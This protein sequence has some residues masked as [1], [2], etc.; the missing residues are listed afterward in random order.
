MDSLE[1]FHRFV[2]Q[3]TDD[4]LDESM[5]LRS[6]RNFF[7]ADKR[8]IDIKNSVKQDVFSLGIFLGEEKNHF[9]PSP[10]CIDIIS[11]MPGAQKRKIFINKKAEWLFLC[12]RAVLEQ[13]I[14]KNP[15]NLG[16]GSVLVQNEQD[17]NLGY[18]FFKQEGKDLV[19]RNILDK[20][21]YLRMDERGRRK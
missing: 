5:V 15:N 14:A 13:S 9:E 19:I 12:G 17:E 18:G 6:G 20:G 8:L 3:F 11:K 10:A 1:K 16:E 7:Y 21:K 2:S 4:E